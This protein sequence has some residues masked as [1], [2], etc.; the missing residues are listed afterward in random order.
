MDDFTDA[1]TLILNP[2]DKF[3]VPRELRHQ[4][5]GLEDTEMYE[6]STTHFESDSYRVKK[7]D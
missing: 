1:D 6:F 3:E 2:G 5:M 4:M 7:G